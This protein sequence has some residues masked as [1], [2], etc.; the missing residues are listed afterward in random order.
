MAMDFGKT[1]KIMGAWNQFKANHPKFPAFCK[2]VMN[3]GI[4]EDS[5]IEIAVIS[6]EGQ[7]IETNLKVKASDLEL[8]QEIKNMGV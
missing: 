7:R 5:V 4:R 8:F 2:A 3:Q 6:P 1:M